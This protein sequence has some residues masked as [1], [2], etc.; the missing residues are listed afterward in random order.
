[1]LIQQK[2]YICVH[3]NMIKN[4]TTAFYKSGKAY[5]IQF[6]ILINK[7]LLESSHSY[8]FLYL[9]RLFFQDNVKMRSCDKDP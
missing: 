9:Q 2:S 3:F 8:S 4:L 7:V 6:P 5:G 1:M